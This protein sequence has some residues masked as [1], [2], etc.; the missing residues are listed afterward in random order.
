MQKSV[1]ENLAIIREMMNYTENPWVL[2][3]Y[4]TMLKEVRGG[5]TPS[6][7]SIMNFG[8]DIFNPLKRLDARE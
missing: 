7:L 8:Y 5:D 6:Y 4:K 2:S 1:E 3:V